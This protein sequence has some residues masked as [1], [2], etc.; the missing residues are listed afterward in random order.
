MIYTFTLCYTQ[1]RHTNTVLQPPK[2][3]LIYKL[4]PSQ[5]VFYL[6]CIECNHLASHEERVLGIQCFPSSVTSWR[7]WEL[8]SLTISR[9]PQPCFPF[10]HTPLP[11]PYY[12][13]LPSTHWYRT[14]HVHDVFHHTRFERNQLLSIQMQANSNGIAYTM[15]KV[16]FFPLNNDHAKQILLVVQQA[17]KSW[18]FAK[19]LLDQTKIWQENVSSNLCFVTHMWHWM[20]LQIIQRMKAKVIQTGIRM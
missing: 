20:K 10:L 17:S 1:T 11:F 9:G 6:K 2:K 5:N 15:I 16:R 18:Q 14:E 8:L 3:L 7:A 13:P 12:S 4:S 19:F